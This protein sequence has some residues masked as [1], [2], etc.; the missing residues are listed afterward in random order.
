MSLATWHSPAFISILV[1]NKLF[2]VTTTDSAFSSSRCFI[3]WPDV[4]RVIKMQGT[5]LQTVLLCRKDELAYCYFFNFVFFIF[6]NLSTAIL[7]GVCVSSQTF[8]FY[9]ELALCSIHYYVKQYLDKQVNHCFSFSVE[10]G[11]LIIPVNLSRF[12]SYA[13]GAFKVV[14][15]KIILKLNAFYWASW[16]KPSS[17]YTKTNKHHSYSYP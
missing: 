7:Q 15:N 13:I 4:L 9:I 17:W 11:M 6:W 2:L 1:V 14:F 8:L 5:L 16:L 3:A 12:S 10:L